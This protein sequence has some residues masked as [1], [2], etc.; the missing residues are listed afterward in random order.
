MGVHGMPTQ[1]GQG[2]A[3]L[4][5]ATTAPLE[6]GLNARGDWN[7]AGCCHT[8]SNQYELPRAVRPQR[9]I[10]SKVALNTEMVSALKFILVHLLETHT[11]GS[12]LGRLI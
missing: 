12:I 2:I 10:S 6:V 11:H 7:R 1:G 8:M 4:A 5:I 9:H 3:S